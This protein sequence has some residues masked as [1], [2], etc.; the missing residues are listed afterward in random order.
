LGVKCFKTILSLTCPT[1]FIFGLVLID[2]FIA[3]RQLFYLFSLRHRVFGY[4]IPAPLGAIS[5]RLLNWAG[6]QANSTNSGLATSGLTR[7]KNFCIFI[8][9]FRRVDSLRFH[10]PAGRKP[11]NRYRQ[12]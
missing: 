1:A 11:A 9:P 10:K 7:I 3:L 4:L 6:G 12:G 8:K 2:V 5:R